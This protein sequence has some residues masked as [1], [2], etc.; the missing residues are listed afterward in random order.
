MTGGFSLTTSFVYGLGTG[1]ELGVG[2]GACVDRKRTLKEFFVLTNLLSWE[3]WDG[4]NLAK[5]S[6]DRYKEADLHHKSEV[7]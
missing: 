5:H 2:A 1:A 4:A 6:A 3:G 7:N